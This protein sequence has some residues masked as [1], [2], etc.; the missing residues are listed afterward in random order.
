M[1]M[2]PTYKPADFGTFYYVDAPPETDLVALVTTL[3]RWN[4]VQEAYIDQAAPDPVVNAV[5]DP[6]S[7][8]QGYLDPAPDGIDA[9][10]A[11]TFTGGD[12]AGQRFIDLERGWTWTMRISWPMELRC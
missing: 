4:S 2:D 5:D 12:G 11:W 8:N 6:R 9:E 1:E 3:L 10:Y 7:V